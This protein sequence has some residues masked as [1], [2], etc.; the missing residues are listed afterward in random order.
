MF[1]IVESQII[2]N[3]QL[4]F[5]FGSEFFVIQL[6]LFK[7]TKESLYRGVVSTISFSAHALFHF[8]NRQVFTVFMASI[9]LPRM[10]F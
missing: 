4:C 5:F 1:S 10:P 7:A 3:T 8:H 6:L 2:N 9:W